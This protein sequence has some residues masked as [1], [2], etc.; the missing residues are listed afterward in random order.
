[1]NKNNFTNR[2]ELATWIVNEGY[3]NHF[4]LANGLLRYAEDLMRNGTKADKDSKYA[5]AMALLTGKAY[6]SYLSSIH[7]ASQGLIEDMGVIV[8]SL[9]NL[10]I[11]AHW[12]SDANREAR[13]RRYIG[14]F[15]IEMF[16]MT[17]SIPAPSDVKEQIDKMYRANKGLFQSRNRSGKLLIWTHWHNS[18]IKQ[19]A[20][21]TGMPHY[22]NG[23]YVPL[24]A[25]EHS[26]ALSYFGMAAS[27][28]NGDEMVIALGDHRFLSEY[29][30]CAF[31]CFA[32]VLALWNDVFKVAKEA[33][34]QAEISKGID[35]FKSVSCAPR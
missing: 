2:S 6:K 29:L 26:S 24:S 30:K 22:Y 1:M 21:E 5:H 16:R 4:S 32:D 23:Y 34:F 8:R 14:W 12:I 10:C 31:V 20:T 9:L 13:A 15:W 11:V 27:K 28:T 19:M 25:T 3:K 33:D 35:F 7:L 18:S 17:N